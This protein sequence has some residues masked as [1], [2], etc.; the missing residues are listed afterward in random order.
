MI[1]EQYR[2][3][4]FSGFEKKKAHFSNTEELLDIEW[5]KEFSDD[6]EFYRFSL[7]RDKC[8]HG[9]KPQHTLMVERKNGF[10]WY[11]VAMIRDEDISGLNDL[12]EF[13]PKDKD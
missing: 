3:I 10:Q 4:F 6:D 9:R 7:S 11:V 1:A 12:P 8:K 2:P 13:E 5:V